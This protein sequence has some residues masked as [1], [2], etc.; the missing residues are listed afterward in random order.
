MR[1]ASETDGGAGSNVFW[2]LI[3]VLPSQKTIAVQNFM[4]HTG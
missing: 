3:Y 2:P 4:I 1:S